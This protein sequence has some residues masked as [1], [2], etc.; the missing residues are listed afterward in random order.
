MPDLN[1]TV[2][3]QEEINVVCSSEAR[4]AVKDFRN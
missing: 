3:Q 4:A 1:V 2:Q